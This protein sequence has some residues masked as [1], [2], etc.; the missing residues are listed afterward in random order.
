MMASGGRRARSGGGLPA[1]HS[2]CRVVAIPWHV[3]ETP[4][5]PAV[6]AAGV[7]QDR[8]V[9]RRRIAE[10]WRVGRFVIGIALGVLAFLAVDGQRGELSGATAALTHLRT[11]WLAVGIVSELT[12]FAAFAALQV[13]LLRVGSVSI[14]LPRMFG[15]TL[16]AGAIAS[17]IPAGPVF[18]SLFA[19]RQY[20][21]GGADEA[22]AAWTLV[23][24]LTCTALALTLLATA[25]VLLAEKE[26]AAFDVIGV[27]LGVLIV[28]V[29][30]S[31]I[32]WQ[33]RVV[34][35]LAAGAVRLSQRLFHY[36]R[37]DSGEVVD[38][39]LQ[40]LKAVHMD[41]ADLAG[42]IGWSLGNWILDCGCLVCCFLCVGAHVPWQG[43]LLT[44][45]ASQLAANL[46]ITPGGL[47]V[48]EGSLTIG[49]VAFGGVEVST[50]AA[51]LLYRIISFWAF[52]PIGWLSW[53]AVTLRNRQVDRRADLAGAEREVH[54]HRRDEYLPAPGIPATAGA[55]SR[56]EGD[57]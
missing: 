32:V 51:V 11:Q 26:G 22:L 33:R 54:P 4:P 5:F 52:L 16:G 44:Y 53:G 13:W 55:A 15:I 20:R 43:L 57:R 21:R 37:A 34:V 35:S 56:T 28:A 1:E 8:G 17:S 46:P 10:W 47:G 12:S 36:P 45:G 2:R 7:V 25:G 24:T 49:L 50:V 40:R 19:Y 3:D 23:A 9:W 29:L 31:A 30:A 27:T 38:A 42:A 48:V 18:S 14:P 6:G 39:V 41:F